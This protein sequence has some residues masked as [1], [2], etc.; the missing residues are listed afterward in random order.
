M[1]RLAA[2][3]GRNAPGPARAAAMT[4]ELRRRNL[5]VTALD[6]GATVIRYHAL[7]REFFRKNS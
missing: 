3:S 4:G 5:F 6:D 2:P 1:E 7:F